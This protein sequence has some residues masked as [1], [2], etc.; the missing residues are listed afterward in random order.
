MTDAVPQPPTRRPA[1]T[2]TSPRRDKPIPN[3]PE[4]IAHREDAEV[5]KAELAAVGVYPMS[6]GVYP[7]VDRKGFVRLT[8]DEV[9]R[10]IAL[11]K[12]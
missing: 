7:T 9:R 5:V 8:F 6:P 12:D 4:D 2:H 11:G 10:L 1:P 3:E